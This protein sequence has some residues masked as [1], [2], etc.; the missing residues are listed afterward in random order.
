MQRPRRCIRWETRL[1]L[2][3]RPESE[4]RRLNLKI[5]VNQEEWKVWG[6]HLE[7]LKQEIEVGTAR[8]CFIGEL[9]KHRQTVPREKWEELALDDYSLGEQ[10]MHPCQERR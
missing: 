5:H 4:G 10:D 3:D 6:G 7:R 2:F 8:D 9:V 1:N